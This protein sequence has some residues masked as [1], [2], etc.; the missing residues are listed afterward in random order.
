VGTNETL[1]ES[2]EMKLHPS[3]LQLIAEA[4]YSGDPAILEL[5]QKIAQSEVRVTLLR[6]SIDALELSTRAHRILHDQGVHT[7]AQ[8][9]EKSEAALL[10]PPGFGKKEA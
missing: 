9:V 8:L 6:M 4:G 5:A 2:E 10:K 7:V 3:T 1:S